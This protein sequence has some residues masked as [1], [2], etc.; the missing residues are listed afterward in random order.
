MGGPR[1][2]EG[3]FFAPARPFFPKEIK[4]GH[5]HHREQHGVL[6]DYLAHHFLEHVF[7]IGAVAAHAVG[8]ETEVGPVVAQVPRHDGQQAHQANGPRQ[9]GP[10][11]QHPPG[12]LEQQERAETR[13]QVEP[14]DLAKTGK[15]DGEAE[16][17]PMAA[18]AVPALENDAGH[19]PEGGGPKGHFG[20][21]WQD[22]HAGDEAGVDAGIVEQGGVPSGF[23]AE[24]DFADL[25]HEP[26]GSAATEDAP[27]AEGQ[28]VGPMQAEGGGP[29]H[30]AHDGGMVK[31]VEV[32]L[33][34]V[35]P[36]IDFV[37]AKPGASGHDDLEERNAD[38]EGDQ[39]PGITC[40]NFFDGPKMEGF[41]LFHRRAIV[42][43]AGGPWKGK[44]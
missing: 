33:E 37:V 25:E 44:L 28:A 22:E 6:I 21:V 41:L 27:Q 5:D 24:H 30:E 10:R 11:A 35:G 4:H 18:R 42:Y 16:A 36:I 31:M 12:P 2:E 1:K 8:M 43:E 9:K 7:P 23:F 34:G 38:E 29:D 15:P 39:F 19:E 26:G 32:G 3:P 20:T 17:Q 40:H 13:P 14:V